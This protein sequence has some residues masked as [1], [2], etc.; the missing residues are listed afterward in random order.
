MRKRILSLSGDCDFELVR[1]A[2]RRFIFLFTNFVSPFRN[3]EALRPISTRRNLE[4]ML[5]YPTFNP[6]GVRWH[7]RTKTQSA[8][9]C[10]LVFNCFS[11]GAAV[12]HP[13]VQPAC[14]ITH[15]PPDW[16]PKLPASSV[17]LG[18]A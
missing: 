15:G 9:D 10:H 2:V 7:S 12:I 17:W 16:L 8:C 14:R 13:A 1:I 4:I 6:P 11:K 3:P 18:C 5:H